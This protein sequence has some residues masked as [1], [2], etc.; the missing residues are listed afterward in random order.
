MLLLLREPEAS[1]S[2]K[3]PRPVEQG[4]CLPID[5]KGGIIVSLADEN[6]E[7]GEG[8]PHAVHTKPT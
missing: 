6:T 8:D 1:G 2:I 7:Q 4:E 3:Q 5:D